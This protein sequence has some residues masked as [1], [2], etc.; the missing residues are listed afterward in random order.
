MPVTARVSKK[1]YEQFGEDVVAELVD[2]FNEVDA[3][4]KTNLRELNELNFGRFD[5]KLEQRLAES[6]ARTAKALAE[7]DARTSKALAAFEQRLVELE[8]R[9]DGKLNALETRLRGEIVAT[10]WDVTKL[11]F[12]LWASLMIPIIGLWFR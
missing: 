6:E 1:F 9:F 8:A 7:S 11:V 2:W 10:K 4:Y 5:A 12:A 3:T